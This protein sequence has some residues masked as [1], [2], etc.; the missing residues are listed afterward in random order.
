[1]IG[2]ALAQLRITAAP[3]VGGHRLRARLIDCLF[4]L[5]E[6]AHV[7][8]VPAAGRVRRARLVK[9]RAVTAK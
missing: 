6:V 1:M 2:R 3:A 9:E 4:L 5:S 7:Q 8:L